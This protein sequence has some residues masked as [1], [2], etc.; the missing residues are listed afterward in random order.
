MHLVLLISLK[1]FLLSVKYWIEH[2][3]SISPLY[4]M[5]RPV[6]PSVKPAVFPPQEVSI[7]PGCRDRRALSQAH[8]GCPDHHPKAT[9]KGS[10]C[11]CVTKSG[12]LRAWE[13]GQWYVLSSTARLN[14]K[15]ETK[16]GGNVCLLKIT[17]V[18]S[19][20]PFYTA[21]NHVVSCFPVY[22]LQFFLSLK[23]SQAPYTTA[24]SCF[25][26]VFSPLVLI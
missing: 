1:G 25:L 7:Q 23:T 8:C 2:F 10:P 9:H 22:R 15:Q 17:K 3:H 24:L 6:R 11:F 26:T 16:T 20:I 14:G 21:S 18:L 4:N 5:E 13:S 19:I 12:L